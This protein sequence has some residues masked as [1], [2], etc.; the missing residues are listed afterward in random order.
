MA[1]KEVEVPRQTETTEVQAQERAKH[2]VIH[3]APDTHSAWLLHPYQ[4]DA[5]QRDASDTNRYTRFN[6]Q[7]SSDR[8]VR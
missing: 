4:E 2:R 3:Q 1:S 7:G 8:A 5:K 6:V